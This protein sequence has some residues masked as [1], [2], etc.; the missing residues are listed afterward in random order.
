M[1]PRYTRL[2][3]IAFMTAMLIVLTGFFQS[4]SNVEETRS[5]PMNSKETASVAEVMMEIL[6]LPVHTNSSIHDDV[7]LI[8]H[9]PAQR[10]IMVHLRPDGRCPHPSLRGRLSGPALV[11]LDNWKYS[12]NDQNNSVL[13]VNYQVPSTGT[14][15]VDIITVFCHDF[16]WGSR[17]D[18]AS[19][20]PWENNYSF[21]Q[22][23]TEPATQRQLTALDT[24]ITVTRQA[25]D[26]LGYWLPN[27]SSQQQ[28]VYTRYQLPECFRQ[29]SPE[30]TTPITSVEPFKAY[31]WQWSQN[32]HQ[33]KLTNI[34]NFPFPSAPTK[35][36]VLGASHARMFTDYLGRHGIR[37]ATQNL[38][39]EYV[40]VRMPNQI[41]PGRIAVVID[42]QQCQ[43][44]IISVGQWP[45]GKQFRVNSDSPHPFAQFYSGYK[46]FLE[47]IHQNYPDIH[48]VVRSINYNPIGALIGKCPANDWRT[49]TA[50]DG[51]NSVIQHAVEEIASDKIS[52]V[53]TNFLVG[54]MWDAAPDWCHLDYGIGVIQGVYV[55]ACTLGVL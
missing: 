19:L 25:P 31:H 32:D 9:D 3:S 22:T 11:A 15:F 43:R 30:C 21:K 40:D 50:I 5:A 24:T 51:Y 46:T 4:L 52:W 34:E 28:P 16:I 26:A 35:V 17:N 54:P 44:L 23:C 12:K 42:R 14:Y 38:H 55:L 27:N 39:V 1:V 45:A 6:E 48:V 53:D 20:L 33:H 36:C 41:N 37:N 8:Q 7:L 10:A 29:A 49:P 47:Y 2:K 18:T 13:T